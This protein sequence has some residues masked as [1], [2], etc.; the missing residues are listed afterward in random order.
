MRAPRPPP[1]TLTA[2]SA[3]QR[4]ASAHLFRLTPLEEFATKAIT[5]LY[6]EKAAE[7]ESNAVLDPKRV[8]ELSC[9]PSITWMKPKAPTG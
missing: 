6:A 4:R 7:D 2:E 8:G 5:P 1:V 3:F 9:W